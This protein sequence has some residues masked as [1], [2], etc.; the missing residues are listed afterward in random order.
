MSPPLQSGQRSWSP[1]SLRADLINSRQSREGLE[2]VVIKHSLARTYFKLSANDY[3]LACLF[4]GRRSCKQLAE[5]AGEMGFKSDP[6]HVAAL[7]SQLLERGLLVANADSHRA[8]ARRQ[9]RH[10][11][12]LG[13]WA[14]ISGFL[15]ARI[16]LVDPDSMLAWAE[17]RLRWCW[18]AGAVRFAGIL[19]AGACLAVF[20]RLDEFPAAIKQSMNLPN[21]AAAWILLVVVKILHELGHGLTCKHY[22]GEV[23]ELGLLLILFSPFFY[24][25]VSDSY[26]FPKKHQRVL[27][28]AAGIVV[29]LV[30]AACAAIA[31]ALSRPGPAREV[32]FAL[33]MITSIWTVLFN[34]NPLMKF[35]GYYMLSDLTGVPNLRQRAMSAAVSVID[36]IFF[37]SLLPRTSTSG[38]NRLTWLTVFGFASQMYLLLVITGIFAL[39]RWFGAEL[40][41]R[42]AGDALGFVL[43]FGML[44]IPMFRYLSERFRWMASQ[45]GGPWHPRWLQRL[46]TVAV[47]IFAASWLPVPSRPVRKA[48]VTPVQT[49]V[50]RSEIAGRLASVHVA[51]GQYVEPGDLLMTLASPR[52]NSAVEQAEHQVEASKLNAERLL[53]AEAPGLLVQARAEVL[54]AEVALKAAK[55][56]LEKTRI[57]SPAKGIVVT[58]EIDC[59]HGR[60]YRPG[61]ILCEIVSEGPYEAYVPVQEHA[62]DWLPQQ[63]KT[64]VRLRGCSNES[65]V[66]VAKQAEHTE[67]FRH[68]PESIAQALEKELAVV[69]GADGRML[70][71]ETFFGVRVPLP[72]A[73]CIR[74]GMTGCVQFDCGSSPLGRWLWQRWLE[75]IDPHYRL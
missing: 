64:H 17:K 34:A 26:L 13:F 24:V 12:W 54:A 47:I 50:I 28:A 68:L 43:L 23:R 36:R 61:E 46:A 55:Q 10:S 8:I 42:W 6:E 73:A 58:Q 66:A 2:I 48:L 51:V 18:S 71:V 9:H 56:N 30:I 75:F 5:L 27:V 15:F 69:T 70:P 14:W 38:D 44:G 29:E 7:A 65:Y 63:A 22:G 59:Q 45:P 11:G 49:A 33:M 19:L 72:S 41:L 20:S 53:G 62:M 60:G 52:L 31:W 1:P 39:F 25:N 21:L 40:G 16:P 35:D 4:D 3:D 37:G 74:P 67:P 32:L 57:R